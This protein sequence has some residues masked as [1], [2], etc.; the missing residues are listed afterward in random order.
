M[1]FKKTGPDGPEAETAHENAIVPSSQAQ[2]V[3]AAGAS[4]GSA[5]AQAAPTERY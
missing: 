1:I 5:P 2:Q 3:P 4:A